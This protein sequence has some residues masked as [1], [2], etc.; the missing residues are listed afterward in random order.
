[1]GLKINFEDLIKKYDLTIEGIIHV[2]AHEGQEVDLYE[3]I[4]V[5][6]IMLFEP[7]PKIFDK[8]NAKYSKDYLVFDTAL[9][10]IEGNIMMNI[11][12]SNDCKSSSILEPLKHIDYYP[13]IVFTEKINIKITKLDNFLSYS[14][15]FNVMVIDTQGYELEVLKGSE[16]FLEK[17]DNI[18]CEVNNEE[19]Y[20]GCPDVNELDEYLK[21]FGFNRVETSWSWDNETWG[22]AL[23]IKNKIK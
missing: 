21:T 13:H 5:K 22:D 6:N 11:E 17:I 9:G 15:R 23:Y 14:D 2:G 20:M 10:N 18:I 12:N 3:R 1:M 4:G 16:K 7:I 8:L 19:L